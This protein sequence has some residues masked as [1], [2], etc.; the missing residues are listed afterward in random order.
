MFKRK[1][2][3]VDITIT[4]HK[5]EKRKDDLGYWQDYYDKVYDNFMN[6]GFNPKLQEIYTNAFD[7]E[8]SRQLRIVAVKEKIKEWLKTKEDI[9]VAFK[10][11]KEYKSATYTFWDYSYPFMFGR[12][13]W[14][15]KKKEDCEQRIRREAQFNAQ[16]EIDTVEVDIDFFNYVIE[17]WSFN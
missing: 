12:I 4:E 14:E 17:H 1:Y 16:K 13:D 6:G 5:E 11:Q 3:N 2:K 8:K 15:N 9:E 10:L 7:N